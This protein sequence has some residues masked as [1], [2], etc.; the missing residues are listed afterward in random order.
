MNYYYTGKCKTHPDATGSCPPGYRTYKSKNGL[1]C[2]KV[3]SRDPGCPKNRKDRKGKR[4]FISPISGKCVTLAGKARAQARLDAL[5]AY[6]GMFTP[7]RGGVNNLPDDFDAPFGGDEPLGEYAS[8]AGIQFFGRKRRC[9]RRKKSCY[10]KRPSRYRKAGAPCGGK[11]RKDCRST[12]GCSYVKKRGCR[13]NGNYAKMIAMGMVPMVSS[14]IAAAGAAAASAAE[15]SGAPP[16]AVAAAA[17]AGA[18]DAAEAEVLSVGGTPAE[19]ASAAVAAAEVAAEATGAPPEAVAE[20]VASVAAVA[21]APPP[22]PPPPGARRV[23][24][25][26]AVGGLGDMVAAAARARAA[27]KGITL[28][29]RR[30]RSSRFGSVCTD[31]RPKDIGTCLNYRDSN[32]MYPCNW[33][34]GANSRCQSRSGGAVPYSMASTAGKY[35]SYVMATTPVLASMTPPP[36]PVPIAPSLPPPPPSVVAAATSELSYPPM[37]ARGLY[38]CVGRTQAN[39]GSNPNCQW[40]AGGNPP[41]CVRRKGHLQGE[42][43]EGPMLASEFGR[44]RRKSKRYNV[45]GSGC[46]GRKKRD[47]NKPVCSYT[48]RRGCRRSSGAKAAGLAFGKKRKMYLTAFG[49]KRKMYLTSFGKKRKSHRR[50]KGCKSK[51]A[52]KKLPAKVRAMCRK[53]K[54]KTTKKVGRRRVCKSLKT[55]MAQIR[56]KMRKM[57]KMKKVRRK[58]HHRRR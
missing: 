46:Q 19:A 25:P 39:C 24:G 31:L 33:S 15:A 43:Y 58:V 47:C 53:L 9:D 16:E 7:G 23:T 5:R 30:R 3:V 56:R 6:G 17:A 32:G 2:R 38:A 13:R 42:Q 18:A 52:N 49:K 27:R 55:I 54:I 11:K 22:P 40:Q 14:S 37:A 35:M 48:K 44:R 41:K 12:P 28:F 51:G 4:R 34:G 8:E 45:K 1:C 26:V 10:K 57:K 29:G 21:S 36:T 20:A 50:R